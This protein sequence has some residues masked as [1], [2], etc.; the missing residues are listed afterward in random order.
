M[1]HFIDFGEVIKR[2]VK[3]LIEGIIVAIVA[4]TIPKQSLKVEEVLVIAL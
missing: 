4:Y 1:S 3:Y 2:I